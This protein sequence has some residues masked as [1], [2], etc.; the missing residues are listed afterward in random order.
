MFLVHFGLQMF[1]KALVTIK[2]VGILDYTITYFPMAK[3]TIIF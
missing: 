2:I 3:N 1:F